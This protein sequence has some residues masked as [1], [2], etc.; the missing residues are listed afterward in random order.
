ML[1]GL[2]QKVGNFPGVTVDKKT[3]GCK[4]SENIYNQSQKLQ[5]SEFLNSTLLS[6]IAPLKP[7]E[8]DKQ[9]LDNIQFDG[10]TYDYSYIH[11]VKSSLIPLV[12]NYLVGLEIDNLRILIENNDIDQVNLFIKDSYNQISHKDTTKE[13]F[14]FVVSNQ[15]LIINIPYQ[16]FLTCGS[17][18]NNELLDIVEPIIVKSKPS[19]KLK[20]SYQ[21]ISSLSHKII[22]D[23]NIETYY[24]EVTFK[25]TV[26]NDY[27]K[28]NIKA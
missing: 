18:L 19:L 4:I 24:K 20:I 2:N 9:L 26:N 17:K 6:Y 25:F 16:Y 13:Y 12:P 10:K 14:N 23:T 27:K 7:V 11:Y 15:K 5:N 1:T 21:D 8:V 28:S 22:F 3:G